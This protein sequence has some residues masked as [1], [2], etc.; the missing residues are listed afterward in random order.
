MTVP[1]PL[2]G[3]SWR[4]NRGYRV[5][6]MK[7]HDQCL[8]QYES[9]RGPF[10]DDTG[11]RW[12]GR[13]RVQ[14]MGNS[15]FKSRDVES[16]VYSPHHGRKS[17]SDRCGADHP[18]DHEQSHKPW[19]QLSSSPSYGDVLVRE[20]PTLSN[21]VDGSRNSSPV[22]LLLNPCRS[23]DEVRACGPPCPSAPSD[24][25]PCRWYPDLLLLAGEQWGLVSLATLERGKFRG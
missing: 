4:L 2:R 23:L 17:E 5:R 12:E 24:K 25:C 6:S 15:G 3:A 20:P 7:V 14:G 18:Q 11:G 9:G 10:V 1:P 21:S 8:V 13:G 16:R 22:G 19:G